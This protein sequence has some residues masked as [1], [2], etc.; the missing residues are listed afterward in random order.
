MSP[1]THTPSLL[2]PFFLI[3]LEREITTREKS[4]SLSLAPGRW[5]MA[6]IRGYVWTPFFSWSR[7]LA[8]SKRWQIW[9]KGDGNELIYSDFIGSERA[10]SGSIDNTFSPRW[11]AEAEEDCMTTSQGNFTTRFILQSPYFLASTWPELHSWGA[12]TKS[13]KLRVAKRS[14]EKFSEKKIKTK[15]D[16]VLMSK[17]ITPGV[18]YW[19]NREKMTVGYIVL[20]CMAGMKECFVP[21]TPRKTVAWLSTVQTII[22]RKGSTRVFEKFLCKEIWESVETLVDSKKCCF[23]FFSFS[24]RFWYHSALIHHKSC[25]YNVSFSTSGKLCN[26][27]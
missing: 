1:H 21:V 10:L 15:T 18:K 4:T 26:F 14:S 6:E 13:D 27:V 9:V 12:I 7:K 3:T 8:R 2:F 25:R 23:W 20:S 5:N 24:G 11:L 22:I 16:F 19:T 17:R